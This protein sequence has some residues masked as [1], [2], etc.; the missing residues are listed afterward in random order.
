MPGHL[1]TVVQLVHGLAGLAESPG[2]TACN[3]MPRDPRRISVPKAM[4]YDTNGRAHSVQDV[5]T[6][7]L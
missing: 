7:S 3:I 2:A 5:Q 6:P 4:R 1:S